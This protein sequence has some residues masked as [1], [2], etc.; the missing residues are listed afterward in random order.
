VQIID[1]DGNRE[2]IFEEMKK[3]KCLSIWNF[4]DKFA[5]GTRATKKLKH[6]RRKG[7]RLIWT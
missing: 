4:F 1:R 6:K 2:M 3:A 5:L 7:G